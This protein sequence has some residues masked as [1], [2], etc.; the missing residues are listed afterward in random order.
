M[1]LASNN[2]LPC[3]KYTELT[4]TPNWLYSSLKQNCAISLDVVLYENINLQTKVVVLF[5]VSDKSFSPHLL[6]DDS[7]KTAFQA[8][9]WKRIYY[10]EASI[11]TINDKR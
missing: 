4:R 9:L 5:D 8:Y 3:T 1:I 7:A 6:Q 11:I 10:F 2:S